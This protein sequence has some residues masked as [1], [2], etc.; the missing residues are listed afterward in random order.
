M[1][2]NRYELHTGP[3][4]AFEL[5]TNPQLPRFEELTM[6]KHLHSGF[7]LME[8]MIVVA[9]VG[10]LA[11]IAYPAFTSALTKSRRAEGRTALA[12]LL[13]QQERFMTQT[14]SYCAFSNTAGT[15]AVVIGCATVPFKTYSGD[16]ATN[17][18][19]YLSADA[20]PPADTD[21]V[22]M[23]ECVRVS[24]TPVRSDPEAGTL[25][26]LSS[27]TKTCSGGTNTAV[28]WQ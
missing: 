25:Q 12:E 5:A 21:A 9:I 23:R 16:S 7:T 22:A 27:G 26:M 10:I 6:K 2:K 13:Q 28:C 24:A 17:P 20:C 1:E 14:N 18:A 19:Y 8:L 11:S 4:K 15:T 3:F